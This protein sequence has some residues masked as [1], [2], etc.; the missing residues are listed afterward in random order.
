M[1]QITLWNIQCSKKVDIINLKKKKVSELT[2]V[3][4]NDPELKHV[5]YGNTQ[6]ATKQ[7]KFLSKI[8]PIFQKKITIDDGRDAAFYSSDRHFSESLSINMLLVWC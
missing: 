6:D 7:N 5:K 4:L 8:F 3:K 1:K 2:I